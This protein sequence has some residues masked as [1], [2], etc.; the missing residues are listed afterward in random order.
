MGV[1]AI[2][3]NR[4]SRSSSN[5]I[6]VTGP[7]LIKGLNVGD[8]G[9]HPPDWRPRKFADDEKVGGG[10]VAAPLASSDLRCKEGT[11]FERLWWV[12]RVIGG[13]IADVGTALIT[14][15]LV[16]CL[17]ATAAAAVV[18]DEE[19]TVVIGVNGESGLQESL[20]EGVL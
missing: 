12:E 1:F 19:A 6:G 14:G 13:T 20:G 11:E 7:G 18:G 3:G 15:D 8:L 16:I 4:Y 2:L 5:C 10:G 17:T 9:D